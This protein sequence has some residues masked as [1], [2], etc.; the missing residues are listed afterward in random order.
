[1]RTLVWDVD[2]VLND[3]MAAWL[4][5][6]NTSRPDSE[7]IAYEAL[8]ANPPHEIIGMEKQAYL[9]SLDAF[10]LS[11]KFLNL[12][13]NPIVL[14]WFKDHGAKFRHTVLT[15]V[16]RVTAH[17]SAQWVMRHFGDWIRHFHFV[18]SKR[19]QAVPH[20][21]S[22]KA[23]YLEYFGKADFFIDDQPTNVETV[24]EIGVRSFLVAQPWNDS[25]TTMADILKVL[26][27]EA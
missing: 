13:P 8:Q 3:L 12:Q 9:D 1:M 26:S 5:D 17:Q 6:L 27:Q 18:P 10:R 14:Q 22:N 15:A 11:D 19:P 7:Q 20:Y 21:D 2:D 24:N 16:P 25:E 23:A 4:K